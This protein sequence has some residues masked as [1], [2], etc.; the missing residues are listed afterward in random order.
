[1]LFSSARLKNE[2]PPKKNRLQD[3]SDLKNTEACGEI[4]SPQSIDAFAELG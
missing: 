4:T 2:A 3:G 1:M